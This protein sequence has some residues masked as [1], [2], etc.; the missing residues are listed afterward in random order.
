M[1]FRTIITH[2]VELINLLLPVL[3]G[4]ALLVFFWGLV[5]FIGKSGDAASHA[6]GRSL[7]IWGVLGL[8]IMIS[9]M[10]LISLFGSD[11]GLFVTG[12]PFL[13]E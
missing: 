13:P 11:L 2:V 8:F 10:G 4:A 6:D 9:F 3:V 1:T 5:K 12:L 7:M